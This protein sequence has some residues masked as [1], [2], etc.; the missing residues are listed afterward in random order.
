M[1]SYIP[2]IKD[3]QFVLNE[4]AGLD[5]VT[6]L[7]GMEEATPDL[8]QAVLDEAGSFAS[9]VI[10]PINRTGDQEGVRLDN[11]V[12]RMPTGWRG[13]YEQFAQGGWTSVSTKKTDGGQGLPVLVSAA[14]EEM[15]NGASVAFGLLSLLSR[16]A[17]NVLSL[18]GSAS[19]KSI[20]LPKL[21]SG[22]WTGTMVLTEPQ[23]GSDLSAVRTRAQPQED[24]TFR[25]AGTKIFITYG[26]HDLTANIAHMVL[27]RIEGAPAGVKGI[28]MFLVPKVLVKEDGS[29][30][31]QN[32]VKCVSIEHKLGLHA[33]P[34]CV[35]AFGDRQGAVG[36]LVGEEN[37]GLEYMFIMMNSA[38]FSVGIEGIGIA[39]RAYQQA[40]AYA[41]ERVQGVEQGSDSNAKVP[42][43]R[44]PDVR[45]MLLSMKSRIE[46]MRA[47]S[48]VVAASMD[49]AAHHPEAKERAANQG[50]VE[51]MM[52]VVKGWFSETG[53]SIASLGIQVHGGTGF[54]EE[55]GAAQHL[56]DARITTIYEGTTG[57]QAM[58][59]VGRKVARDQGREL[60]LLIERMKSTV[61][62]LDDTPSSDLHAIA[63]ALR[64]GVSDLAIAGDF[65]VE[66][67][68]VDPRQALAGS[69]PFQEL[70]GVVAGGWQM[71]RAALA[72]TR[73][74]EDET[75]DRSFLSAKITT[76]RFYADHVLSQSGSLNYAIVHGASA[77]LALEDWQF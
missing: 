17:M 28:S 67:Y 52:P 43:I 9:E 35:M 37:R 8:V 23:A 7:P 27:A 34:T 16:G 66:S 69:V 19:L 14:V 12:P 65:L 48:A 70:L 51:L 71:G 31:E 77:T 39:E 58:D 33:T 38:R 42:I 55:T 49:K 44:H 59:L 15:L 72:A 56:R 62:E 22:E 1:T 76:S 4:V 68:A 30:G 25:I 47:L 29:L 53:L 40:L 73:L 2:P 11:G 60:R 18:A 46:A 26:D 10:A 57:I 13:A 50:F 20:F 64:Q 3:I 41:R 5:E 21:V 61:A 74:M 6:Q 75:R 54:I 24:G 45:R 63:R 32:D 36:Y